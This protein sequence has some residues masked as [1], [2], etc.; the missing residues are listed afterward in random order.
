MLQ[1][2]GYAA[3]VA[4]EQRAGGAGMKGYAE[5]GLRDGVVQ[6]A[7][8]TLTL[9]QGGFA[10][11]LGEE[12]GVLYGNG[13]LIG[14]GIEEAYLLARGLSTRYVVT[15]ERAEYPAAIEQGHQDEGAPLCVA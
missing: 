9:F 12:A 3:G 13:G 1:R 15:V 6:L 2:L 10:L 4:G 11:G 7:G 14:Y 5:D 8:E